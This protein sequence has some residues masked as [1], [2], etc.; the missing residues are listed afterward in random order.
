MQLRVDMVPDVEWDG[1]DPCLLEPLTITHPAAV[2]PEGSVDSL[3]PMAEALGVNEDPKAV[4]A[5]GLNLTE[6][7]SNIPRPANLDVAG[8]GHL[9][10]VQVVAVSEHG[11]TLPGVGS[12]P[13][14]RED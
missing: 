5:T 14:R 12:L 7:P 13:I 9:K 11:R 1:S 8:L 6:T 10:D 2:G 3:L 4:G